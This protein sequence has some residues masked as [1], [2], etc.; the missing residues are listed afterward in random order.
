MS[1]PRILVY[2][3]ETTPIVGYTWGTYQTDVIRVIEPSHQLCFAYRWYGSD[4]PVKVVSQ[5]QFGRSYKRNLRDDRQLIKAL[6]ELFDEADIIVAHNGNNFDQKKA[7]ARM[8]VHGLPAPSPYI[9]V[10]TLQVA[11]RKFKFE[12]NRLNELGIQL[13]VG[14]KAETG[15][16]DTWVGCMSGDDDAWDLM[17][18]YNA[19]DVVLLEAVYEKLLL[20]GWIDNHPNLATISGSRHA[21]PK[22]GHEGQMMRRGLRYTKTMA[23]QTYQCGHC[24]SYSSERKSGTGPRFV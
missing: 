23:Y 18:D 1:E 8:A 15:G 13:G 21:C 24:N 9:Q 3:I 11:R 12:S 7:Q 17:E 5:R 19:Q 6:W 2:D 16:F 4:E 10:D 14:E 22:C 20:G